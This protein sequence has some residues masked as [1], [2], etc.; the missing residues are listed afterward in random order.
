MC[1]YNESSVFSNLLNLLSAEEQVN[2]HK[3]LNAGQP[4]YLELQIYSA[5]PLTQVIRRQA[6]QNG[7]STRPRVKW[8]N[9]KTASNIL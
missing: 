1:N 3:V 9:A 7:T 5:D 2:M 8:T 6:T 4:F